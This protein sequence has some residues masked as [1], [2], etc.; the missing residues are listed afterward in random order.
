MTA[1][2]AVALLVG[3]AALVATDPH[4]GRARLRALGRRDPVLRTAPS[5]APLRL[6]WA[7]AGSVSAG[8]AG[9]L[10]GGAVAGAVVALTVGTGLVVFARRSGA[11]AADESASALAAGWELL[12]VCLEAGMPVSTA[13]EAGAAQLDGPSGRAL[14][15]VAGLLELGADPAEAWQAVDGRPAL[16]AFARAARRSAATG[17]GIAHVARTEAQRLR[18]ETVDS[19][20]ARAQRAA[21]TITGP[22]GL[23]FLPAF[24]VLGI[25]PVV[26]GL[27][28][29]ALARW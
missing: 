15:R 10:V 27:A 26:V 17:A 25:A 23:C 28:G 9:L 1:L 14:R 5:P 11:P 8:A 4:V 13:V 2:V 21:V 24:L 12:A 22:L 18:A 7:V 29:D 16:V 3:A 20:R 19:A 6:R